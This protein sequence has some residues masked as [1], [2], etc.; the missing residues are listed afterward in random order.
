MTCPACRSER[1]QPLLPSAIGDR[2]G[3][4]CRNCHH[5]W[6]LDRRAEDIRPLKY[7][8]RRA[9]DAKKRFG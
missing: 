2:P 4:A 6:Q 3:Y 1:V 7:G 8:E 5:R 9:P